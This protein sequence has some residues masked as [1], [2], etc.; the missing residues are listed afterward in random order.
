MLDKGGDL[1]IMVA[2]LH[3][4]IGVIHLSLPIVLVKR[5][6][7]PVGS[8]VMK[9]GSFVLQGIVVMRMISGIDKIRR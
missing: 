8:V 4:I 2:L 9:I 6:G 5:M 1:D 3:L 7:F